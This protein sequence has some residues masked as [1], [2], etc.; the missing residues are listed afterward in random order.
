MKALAC[1]AAAIFLAMTGLA[2]PAPADDTVPLHPVE[3]ACVDYLMSG[4]MQ[5]GTITRCHRLHA[6]EQYE[7]RRTETKVA[8][9]AQS[10]EQHTVTIGDTIYTIDRQA[11]RATR[12]KNPSY[13]Q[14]AAALRDKDPAERVEA[15]AAAM[16][17]TPTGESRTVA[18]HECAV[19][20]SQMMGRV[21]LSADGLML[22]Q[23]FMGNTIRATRVGL[24]EEGDAAVYGLPESLPVS[25]A[26]ALP[27]GHDLQELM[28]TMQ[29]P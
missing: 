4:A 17:F 27:G 2:P 10:R 26:P 19:Y 1:G 25:D 18:G 6:Q 21:C 3:A 29:G 28:K 12:M 24:G 9:L 16:G 15:F 11:G 7:V 5:S 14:M 20:D 13:A 22:E 8:G 23:S